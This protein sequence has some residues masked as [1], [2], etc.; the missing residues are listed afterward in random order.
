MSMN[1]EIRHAASRSFRGNINTR[2]KSSRLA[3]LIAL[4][5]AGVG[6]LAL[7]AAPEAKAQSITLAQLAGQWQIALGGHTTTCGAPS[8]LFNAPLNSS[9]TAQVIVTGG[10]ELS[11]TQTFSITSLNSHGTGT[12]VLSCTP[13]CEL[14]PIFNL[15]GDAT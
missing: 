3:V 1:S 14:G 13:S 5:L 15:H 10:C 8:M 9:G 4:L 6:S 2:C 12:A 7:G 11:G